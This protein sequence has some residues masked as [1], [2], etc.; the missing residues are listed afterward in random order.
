VTPF[1]VWE[2]PYYLWAGYAHAADAYEKNG[3]KGARG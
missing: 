1:N 2:L 3:K